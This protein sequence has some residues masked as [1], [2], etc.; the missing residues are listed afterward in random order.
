MSLKDLWALLGSDLARFEQTYRLRGQS[1]SKFKAVVESFVFKPGFQGV[2]LYRISHWLYR[3]GWLYAAWLLTRFS[4][5]I[6]G[7]E[8]EF[9]ATIGPGLFIAHP[10]GIVIGRGTVIG[11]QATLFQGVTFGVKRWDPESIHKFPKVGNCCTF[12]S[13]CTIVGGISIGDCCVIG[14]NTLVD[15]DLPG[16]SLAVGVPAQVYPNKGRDMTISSKV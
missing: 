2:L 8:I 1:Y 16:E 14:A 13:H 9:N 5:A 15:R 10:V 6:T 7:A 3:N 12:F 4:V 11:G